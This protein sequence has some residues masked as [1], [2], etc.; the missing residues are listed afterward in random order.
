MALASLNCRFVIVTHS[1]LV[2]V[3]NRTA[4]VPSREKRMQSCPAAFSRRFLR[5]GL[6]VC[7]AEFGPFPA[8]LTAIWRNFSAV[9]TA[10]RREWDSNPRYP[11]GYSGFQEALSLHVP[12]RITQHRKC[13]A[14]R[15]IPRFLPV[16]GF[17]SELTT[18]NHFRRGEQG[19]ASAILLS[20][21][22]AKHP[23]KARL[24]PGKELVQPSLSAGFNLSPQ[25]RFGWNSEKNAS[26]ACLELLLGGSLD[27][28]FSKDAWQ[29]A[30]E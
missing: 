1:P 22:R 29:M 5:S 9:Q 24:I 11:S 8:I 14:E 19:A 16:P 6:R 13:W 3:R 7:I 30:A 23:L 21:R 20:K 28:Q 4:I 2:H 10:W 18:R 25:H 15:S 17:P 12:S 26:A 27:P